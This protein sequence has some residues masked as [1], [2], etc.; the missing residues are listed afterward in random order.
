MAE[1]MNETAEPFDQDVDG[2]LPVLFINSARP[3]LVLHADDAAA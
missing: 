2:T 1:L 3:V